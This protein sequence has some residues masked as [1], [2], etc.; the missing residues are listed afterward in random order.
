[1]SR[2]CVAILFMVALLGA[3]LG[4]LSAAELSLVLRNYEMV[5]G[6]RYMGALD[7][8][9]SSTDSKRPGYRWV[10]YGA[11]EL[12]KEMQFSQRFA[13]EFD[14]GLVP[15]G[16][17]ARATVCYTLKFTRDAQPGRVDL[18]VFDGFPYSANKCIGQVNLGAQKA[19]GEV[20]VEFDVTEAIAA[21]TNLVAFEL[22]ASYPRY[23]CYVFCGGRS[24]PTPRNPERVEIRPEQRPALVV[25]VDVP[26]D[27]PAPLSNAQVGV[28]EEARFGPPKDM[29]YAI[30]QKPISS[31]CTD[32]DV[33]SG[34]LRPDVEGRYVVRGTARGVSQYATIEARRVLSHRPRVWV[35]PEA[36][37]RLKAL[38]TMRVPAWVTLEKE[39]NKFLAAIKDGTFQP[40]WGGFGYLNTMDA[41]S[42]I[43][44]VTGD[45]RYV[46]PAKRLMELMATESLGNV[47]K[48]IGY[49]IRT[50][51]RA[52]AMGIDRLY[53]ELSADEKWKYVD[54]LNH[55]L[56]WYDAEGYQSYGPTMGNYFAGYFA[57]LYMA[58]Y[59][60][61][62]DNPRGPVLFDRMRELFE[63]H[64]AAETTSGVLQ[65]GDDPEGR[66]ADFYFD[67]WLRYLV[68]R[69]DAGGED[70]LSDLAWPREIVYAYIH[71]TR[72]D[73][74]TFHDYGAWS[75]SNPT[76]VPTTAMLLLSA[77]L[78]NTK[79]GAYAQQFVNEQF[80]L[81]KKTPTVSD[82]LFYDSNR[83]A[84]GWEEEPCSYYT[85]GLNLATMRSSWAPS[86]V[87]ASFQ[88]AGRRFVDHQHWDFGHWSIYRGSDPLVVDPYSDD[89]GAGTQFH[90]CLVVDDGGTQTNPY[91]PRQCGAEGIP[92]A[93]EDTGTYVYVAGDFTNH[94]RF[95]DKASIK[96]HRR[97][98]LYL[99]P[100]LFIILDHFELPDDRFSA[101]SRIHFSAPPE[102][103]GA[104]ISA[105]RN[106]SRVW[107]RAFAADADQLVAPTILRVQGRY[108]EN[109]VDVLSPGRLGPQSIILVAAAL[110]A[111]EAPPR[112]D[113]E[114]EG[115]SFRVRFCGA[116]DAEV[117]LH[118]DGSPGG[119]VIIDGKTCALATDIRPLR[120]K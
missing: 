71:R 14:L 62:Q 113:C 23:T 92:L 24:G 87:W 61:Y 109:A 27:L 96:M 107:L 18:F 36:L 72:P 68:A 75:G 118:A 10:G 37:A 49:N 120:S 28:G 58:V 88:N 67:T 16:T 98:F 20:T 86:A 83:R 47:A 6:Q 66:Y 48:D 116:V 63:R 93:F 12:T 80:D 22:R 38:Q 7:Y 70:F 33:A 56:A 105:R 21:A 104:N 32:K 119:S 79:E 46:E 65:G 111:G 90:N 106:T 82:C 8:A 73:K 85:R 117:V 26:E 91:N 51:G 13:T 39:A 1:L 81:Q 60:T 5:R 102:I 76:R 94:Y 4:P 89:E 114:C 59:A 55:W 41:L 31:K 3:C 15:R 101:M 44:L 40:G 19:G 57:A 53:P 54:E 9:Y 95:R 69:R 77:L 50:L 34:M 103:D 25:D 52:M 74:Q 112:V 100:N 97:H 2:A 29:S 35:N 42:L 78:A 45:K 43:Y 99:R 110:G 115:K 30:V 17:I 108:Q 11:W 84:R 64:I